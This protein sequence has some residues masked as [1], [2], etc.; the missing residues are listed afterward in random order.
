MAAV[1]THWLYGRG[2]DKRLDFKREIDVETDCS[3]CIH[4]DVCDLA[5]EKRCE[6]YTFGTSGARGCAGCSHRFTRYDSTPV[7]CFTCPWFRAETL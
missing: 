5:M 3:K 1:K 6:N 2:A 4:R 7:P